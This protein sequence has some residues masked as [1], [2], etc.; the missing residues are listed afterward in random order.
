M[1]TTPTPAARTRAVRF[2]RYGGREVLE[3]RDVPMPRPGKGEVLV[4]VRAA[5]INPGEVMIRTGLL[6]DRL[7]ATFPS[8]QG[9]DL[10]GVVRELGPGVDEFAVGD[11]VL[12]FSWTRSSHAS[13]AAVPATQLIP[14]P[15]ALPWQVAGALSV[16]GPSA[17]AAIRAVAAAPG[18]VVAVSGATGGVGTLVVQ[19]LARRGATVLGIA[20]ESSAGWLT[21]HGATPVAY[22]DGVGERLRAAAPDGIDAFIDLFGPEYVRLAVD[23]GVRPERVDSI[24][25]SPVAVELGVRM[26]GAA[27]VDT[28]EVLRDLAGLLASGEV[29]LPIAATYP[30][31]QVTEAFERLER[32]HTLGKIVLLP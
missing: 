26:D 30:L 6:H 19:L 9:S 23:L 1:A 21:A 27:T 17:Y 24:V 8:G 5:G 22:G 18:D 10:A 14:K 28:V 32:R 4:D 7:P 25:P 29:E 12:G 15:D 13:H 31:D 16:A 3:V 2:D 20:S 11:E